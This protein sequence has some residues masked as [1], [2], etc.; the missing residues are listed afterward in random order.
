MDQR[1]DHKIKSHKTSRRKH[2]KS[3]IWYLSC[4]YFFYVTPK[5]NVTKVKIK[6]VGLHQTEKLLHKQRNHQQSE[7]VTYVIGKI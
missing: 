5:T 3:T 7:K 1:L 2:G 6:Q 4:G